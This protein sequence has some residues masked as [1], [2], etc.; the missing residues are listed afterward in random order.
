M[1]PRHN[2]FR[3][4]FKASMSK[5]TS[6]Q[7]HFSIHIRMTK[8]LLRLSCL[9]IPREEVGEPKICRCRVLKRL[10]IVCE[11]ERL[12]RLE[13]KFFCK[14][15]EIKLL[16]LLG[17]ERA[18]RMLFLEGDVGIRGRGPECSRATSESTLPRK[19]PDGPANGAATTG[20][21]SKV[22]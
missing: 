2:R 15:G 16:L 14:L 12:G 1:N 5:L 17:I 22:S 18:K 4:H 13:C 11:T 10:L 3:K 20:E 9:L 21:G 6:V 8:H 7:I 19:G